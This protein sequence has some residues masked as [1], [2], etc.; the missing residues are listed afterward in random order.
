[1]TSRAAAIDK[2]LASVDWRGAKRVPLAADASFRCY[3]RLIEGDRRAVLM[4][5][6]PPQENIR[7]FIHMARYLRDRGLSA[8]AV[9]AADE[10]GGFALLE[11]LGDDLYLRV[12]DDGADAELL[13]TAAVDLLVALQ[14]GAL[15][16][17]VPPYDE[18]RLLDEARLFIDWYLPALSGAEVAR[19]DRQAFAALWREALDDLA[20]QPVVPVLRDYHADNLMWLADR[21][22]IAR[23]G[24]LDF[25][26]AVIGPPAYD[27]VSLLEDARRDVEAPL[28]E[29]MIARFVAATR[30]D[31]ATFRRAYAVLGAQRNIKIMGIFTRLWRRDGKARYLD[32]IPRVW[33][34]LERD[35]GHP[36]LTRLRAWLDDRVPPDRRGAPAH[37]D[38]QVFSAVAHE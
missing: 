8:P 24:L 9:L 1:M 3:V 31:E 6:P 32:M 13:Y 30:A 38:G 37:G 11:D 33:R 5:A 10:M 17:G 12:L 4:D 29:A 35:L 36:A 16:K 34:H 15:P 27:L 20:E 21:R 18:T 19:E 7:A 28:A 22:G 25:Q 23:V 26:D 14:A 2:F